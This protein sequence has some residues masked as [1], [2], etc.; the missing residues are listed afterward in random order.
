MLDKINYNI[1]IIEKTKSSA[2]KEFFDGFFYYGHKQYSVISSKGNELK[3]Q[4]TEISPV[5][6]QNVLKIALL[7]TGIVP[8]L[9]AIYK[10]VR[11]AKWYTY[12]KITIEPL[13]SQISRIDQ[14]GQSQL[15]QAEPDPHT[16]TLKM[17]KSLEERVKNN[18][19]Q[20]MFELAIRKGS[21]MGVPIDL[22]LN[23]VNE[24]MDRAAELKFPAAMVLKNKDE[25]VAREVG[26]QDSFF[27]I[28]RLAIRKHK[29]QE[30]ISKKLE[31]YKKYINYD[32]FAGQYAA[33]NAALLSATEKIPPDFGPAKELASRGI[34]L[35]ID[36]V[37]ENSSITKEEK[38]ALFKEW[39]D[40]GDLNAKVFYGVFV[41]ERDE[42]EGIGL[43]KKA[44]QSAGP[45][46]LLKEPVAKTIDKAMKEA[47]DE[48]RIE[49]Y[50]YCLEQGD[51]LAVLEL[52]KLGEVEKHLATLKELADQ[53]N[54]EA[55]AMVNDYIQENLKLRRFF[56]SI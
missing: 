47:R 28:A 41:F 13:S 38:E 39:A 17:L 29:D 1:P 2:V 4:E 16:A 14:K 3:L 48:I 55:I 5:A 31:E 19:P 21:G 44:L 53:G 54:E 40:K 26:D 25:A 24:L 6:K 34:A 7:F 30:E 50:T 32:T 49:W 18:D 52:G 15:S 56:K 12:K 11:L 22:N 36:L 20:A 9:A 33:V 51:K 8:L 10:L 35:G 37:E 27:Q 42:K 45:D 23:T 43:L 46:P